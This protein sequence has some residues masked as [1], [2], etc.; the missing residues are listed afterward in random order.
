MYIKGDWHMV[1]AM[2]NLHSFFV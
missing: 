2:V 1:K